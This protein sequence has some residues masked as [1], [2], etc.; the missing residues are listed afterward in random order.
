MHVGCEGIVVGI[1]HDESV[2]GAVLDEGIGIV[3]YRFVGIVHDQVVLD[4]G[5]VEIVHNEDV[6]GIFLI[7]L[8]GVV[9]GAGG[10]E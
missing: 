8:D 6:V 1:F 2:V 3:H 9:V 4:G 7:V 10:M 5:V